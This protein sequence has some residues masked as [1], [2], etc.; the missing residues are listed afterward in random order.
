MAKKLTEEDQKA[1]ASSPETMAKL[2]VLREGFQ[3]EGLMEAPVKETGVLVRRLYGPDVDP[4]RFPP[5]IVV[6]EASAEDVEV[7]ASV[8]RTFLRQSD[9]MVLV[10]ETWTFPTLAFSFQREYVIEAPVAKGQKW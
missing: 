10:R 1:A 5:G 7:P 3:K 8:M 6:S 4:L 2:E 9:L